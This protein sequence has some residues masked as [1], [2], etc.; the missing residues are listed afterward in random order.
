MILVGTAADGS[1][2]SDSTNVDHHQSSQPYSG[3]YQNSYN[4]VVSD[5]GTYWIGIDSAIRPPFFSVISFPAPPFDGENMDS[6][7]GGCWWWSL[8]VVVVCGN[9]DY[10]VSVL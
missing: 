2:R 10:V 7:D 5:G 6:G 9:I 3:S 4:S 8:W 1:D